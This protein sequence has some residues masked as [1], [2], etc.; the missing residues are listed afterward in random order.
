VDFLV[1]DRERVQ[2]L[3]VIELDDSSHKRQDRVTRDDFVKAAIA[4]AGIPI[5]N[6]PCKQAYA[7]EEVAAAVRDGLAVT[8]K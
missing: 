5:I 4:S 8:R 2:P 3:L 7:M 6:Q 1:C